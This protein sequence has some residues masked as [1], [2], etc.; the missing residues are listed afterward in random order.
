MQSLCVFA[1]GRGTAHIVAV[2]VPVLTSSRASSDEGS[3]PKPW[4]QG[5]CS[6]SLMWHNCFMSFG[7]GKALRSSRP[8]GVQSA[9][10]GRTGGC[11]LAEKLRYVSCEWGA[12]QA[13]MIVVLY[14]QRHMGLH[15]EHLR[16]FCAENNGM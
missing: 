8:Y 2:L 5:R 1:G 10:N 12:S 6:V 4:M 11:R 15:P 7:K 16:V 13:K 14:Q 3:F 9:G